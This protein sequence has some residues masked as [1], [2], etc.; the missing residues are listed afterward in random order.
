MTSEID[1]AAI[2][3]VIMNSAGDIYYV[4]DLHGGLLIIRSLT[5]LNFC[6]SPV[7][8]VRGDYCFLYH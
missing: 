1:E 4:H 6:S 3:N 7:R 2:V 5:F 8:V